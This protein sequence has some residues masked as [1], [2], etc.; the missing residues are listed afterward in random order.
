MKLGKALVLATLPV[1]GTYAAAKGY[2]YYKTRDAVDRIAAQAALFGELKYGGISSSLPS[3]TVKIDRLVFTP[4][5]VADKVTLRS[6]SLETGNALNLLNLARQSDS[7]K[8]PESLAVRFDDL[9]VDTDGELLQ[10]ADRLAQASASA[11]AA[12]IS[13]PN[14]GDQPTNGLGMI[15]KLGYDAL[16]ISGSFNFDDSQQAS[17]TAINTQ[18]D[19]HEMASVK[20]RIVFSIGQGSG[21]GAV[22]PAFREFDM[23]YKDLSYKDRLKTYC[24]NAANIS[25]EEYLQAE[26]DH[27]M[28]QQQLGIVP[29]PGLREAYRD[30]LQTPNAEFHAHVQ[31]SESFDPRAAQFYKPEDVLRQL[32]AKISVNNKPVED[33]SFEFTGS[34]PGKAKSE[35]NAKAEKAPTKSK[36]VAIAAY[37]KPRPPEEYSAVNVN[38]LGRYLNKRVRLHQFGQEPREGILIQVSG[39]VALVVRRY[40]TGNVSVKVPVRLISR[41]EV[42]R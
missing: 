12:Q 30:F 42:L 2:V 13:N 9:R 32:N 21:D 25:E 37:R 7:K 39:G 16:S 38:D 35:T 18:F 24:A 22:A 19:I 10:F 6:V 29:G 36:R 5:G 40:G 4:R 31:P 41:A 11:K 20:T 17:N 14:C 1:I 34:R 26:L 8:P 23:T 3:G 33:L 15:R 28:I 27:G